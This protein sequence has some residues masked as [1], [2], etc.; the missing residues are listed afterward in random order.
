L[1]SPGEAVVDM[2]VAEVAV[3]VDL[4]L[5]QVFL[6]RREQITP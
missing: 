4:E 3:L 6:S 2:T 1:S 5:A